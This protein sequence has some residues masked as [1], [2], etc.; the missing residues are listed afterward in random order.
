[1]K[2]GQCLNKI[3]DILYS[4]S[5][6]FHC[7]NQIKIQVKHIVVYITFMVLSFLEVVLE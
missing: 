4:I 5:Y 6:I 7:A 2:I 1:M 3:S